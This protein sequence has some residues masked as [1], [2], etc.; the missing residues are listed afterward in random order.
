MTSRLWRKTHSSL[1]AM[2]A[3]RSSSPAVLK[4]NRL[5]SPALQ[6]AN[7]LSSPA[8]QKTII[9]FGPAGPSPPDEMKRLYENARS[10]MLDLSKLGATIVF[11]ADFHKFH[12]DSRINHTRYDRIILV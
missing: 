1:A 10:Q 4:A 3:N 12:E 6:R 5:S 9:P 7:R 8:V 11:D 2:R